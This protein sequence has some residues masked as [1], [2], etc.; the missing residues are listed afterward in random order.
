VKPEMKEEVVEETKEASGDMLD[1]IFDNA[2]TKTGAKKLSGI[3]KQASRG[4]DSLN[5]LW[6]SPP[7]ISKAFK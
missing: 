6:D 4:D 2:E 1:I 7:D 3:V 5:S